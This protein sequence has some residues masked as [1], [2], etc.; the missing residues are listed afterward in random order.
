MGGDVTVR[1]TVADES[2][3]VEVSDSGEWRDPTDATSYPGLG[4]RLIESISEDLSVDGSRQ[5]TS[6]RFRLPL[7]AKN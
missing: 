2:L 6:V 4:T 5:G 1:I 7:D 3:N